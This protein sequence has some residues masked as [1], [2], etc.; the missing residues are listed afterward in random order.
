MN[1]KLLRDVARHISEEPRRLDME[2]IT[3]R[4][5]E[6]KGEA[7]PCGTAAC[8]AGWALLLTHDKEITG[9]EN[10]FPVVNGRCLDVVD[11]ASLIGDEDHRLFFL[12]SWPKKF[13]EP[14]AAAETPQQRAEIAVARIEHFIKTKGEE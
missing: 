7:P 5:K 9:Y 2:R 3:K 10:G 1:T 11:A 4:G 12:S 13:R 14:Y 8:I 6:I